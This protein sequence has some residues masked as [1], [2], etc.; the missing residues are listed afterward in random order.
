MPRIK[1]LIESDN[2]K[3]NKQFEWDQDLINSFFETVS[4]DI[5]LIINDM[6]YRKAKNE[7]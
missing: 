3:I 7:Q 2:K 5:E 4:Q 1:I 6:Q